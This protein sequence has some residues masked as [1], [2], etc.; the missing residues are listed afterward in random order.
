MAASHSD[1]IQDG[2]GCPV[3]L[4]LPSEVQMHIPTF[5]DGTEICSHG[6]CT[7]CFR[8]MYLKGLHSCSLCRREIKLFCKRL[9]FS[10]GNSC[11]ACE[12]QGRILDGPLNHDWLD[13]H[14]G[15]H[16]LCCSECWGNARQADCECPVC[17]KDLTE[18]LIGMLYDE[19]ESKEEDE[20][21]S[22]GDEDQ[23]RPPETM[24]TASSSSSDED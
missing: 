5:Y 3:C 17:S 4:K 23:S 19:N 8:Q 14:A 10:L 12:I 1:Q 13:P 11:Q 21:S 15:C 22:S 2:A 24:A 16:H 20:E 18:W 7:E 6:H 9:L